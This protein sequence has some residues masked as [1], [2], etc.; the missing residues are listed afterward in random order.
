MT[1]EHKCTFDEVLVGDGDS[2]GNLKPGVKVLVPC[3]CGETPLDELE[4]TQYRNEEL[5]AALLAVDPQ[6][7]LYHWAPA[8]R[9][10][11]I[12]RSGLVPH[13]RTTTSSPGVT[14]CVCLADSPS[15]AWALTLS[16]RGHQ[17][18]WDLWQ[19]WQHLLTEPLVL[20]SP[21][22][23]SGVYEVRTEH[24]VYKRDIWLVGSRVSS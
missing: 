23:P 18:E 3:E 24:R 21:D 15:W 2:F 14:P 11:Q 17:G 7:P 4:F 16:G 19:T 6:R 9:R 1:T 10:K 22:R 13:R 8:N 20:G 12:N 5:S